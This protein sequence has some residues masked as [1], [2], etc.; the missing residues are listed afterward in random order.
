MG[1]SLTL[2][3]IGSFIRL[4][5]CLPAISP[6]GWSK[7]ISRTAVVKRITKRALLLQNVSWVVPT[8]HR[9]TFDEASR[10][11]ENDSEERADEAFPPDNVIEEL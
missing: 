7:H 5:Q 10:V 11:M 1:R 6:H 4:T 8:A 9:V 3:S 2:M